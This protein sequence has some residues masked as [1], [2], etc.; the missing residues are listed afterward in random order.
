MYLIL[1]C[2]KPKKLNAPTLSLNNQNINFVAAPLPGRLDQ[3]APWDE[4]I[5]GGKRT[6]IDC[7][8]D[9]NN[10]GHLNDLDVTAGVGV[11]HGGCLFCSG[12]LYR[13]RIYSDIISRIGFHGLYILSAGWGLVRADHRIPN[14]DITFSADGNTPPHAR[15]TPRERA[16]NKPKLRP[17]YLPPITANHN[18]V[19]AGLRYVDF[20]NIIFPQNDYG[21]ERPNGRVRTYFYAAARGALANIPNI[22]QGDNHACHN[23]CGFRSPQLCCGLLPQQ[24]NPLVVF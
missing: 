16:R 8:A 9:Y 10:L 3:R 17:Q 2:S 19:F 14:Y 5:P 24:G 21:I 20:F 1:P 13:N 6:W 11:S 7:V 12:T 4:I 15:I 18:Q 22:L 23:A